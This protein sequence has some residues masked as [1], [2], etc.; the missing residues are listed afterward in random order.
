MVALGGLARDRAQLEAFEDVE[1]AQGGDP[2]P[3][4]RDLPD[5]VAAV[6]RADRLD[7]AA[8]V[9]AQAGAGQEAARLRGEGGEPPAQFAAVERLGPALADQAQRVR[10]ARR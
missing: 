7:P 10:A 1:R 6:R 3:V 4:R 9:L 2:L 5:L 8:G